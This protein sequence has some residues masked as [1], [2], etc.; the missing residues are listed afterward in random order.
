MAHIEEDPAVPCLT[1]LRNHRFGDHA[2]A[3]SM[4]TVGQDVSRAQA[5]EDFRFLGAAADMHHQRHPRIPG[6]SKRHIQSC[7]SMIRSHRPN[8]YFYPY[9]TRPVLFVYRRGFYRTGISEIHEFLGIRRMQAHERYMD[10][11]VDIGERTIQHRSPEFRKV[12]IAGAAGVHS[13]GDAVS[14]AEKGINAVQAPF[15]PVAMEIDQARTDV[16]AANVTYIRAACRIE[17]RGDLG[18]VSI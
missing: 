15:V 14:D 3:A 11:S 7:E 9:G 4:E 10:E 5:A 16:F 13:G 18:D 2:V 1:G 12:C 8:P 6:G 17:V